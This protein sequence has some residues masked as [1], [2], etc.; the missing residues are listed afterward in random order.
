MFK[1]GW[2]IHKFF[3]FLFQTCFF[4]SSTRRELVHPRGL[5]EKNMGAQDF[6]VSMLFSAPR[7]SDRQ[8]LHT[9]QSIH[10]KKEKKRRWWWWGGEAAQEN[11][12]S[13][14]PSHLLPNKNSSVHVTH[15][16]LREISPGRRNALGL[17]QQ[18]QQ[19]KKK[20]AEMMMVII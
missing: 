11:D 7:S 13:H 6:G 16:N 8:T 10:Q 3:W 4:F 20:K 1:P 5:S 18:Q 15:R 12:D 17:L 19:H 9:H 14:P 2:F